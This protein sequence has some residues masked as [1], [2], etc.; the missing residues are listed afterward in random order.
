MPLGIDLVE[1]LIDPLNA[2][3]RSPS[4]LYH[5]VVKRSGMDLAEKG[6]QFDPPVGRREPWPVDIDLATNAAPGH[7]SAELRIP[8][9]AFDP[10][11]TEPTTWGFNITRYDAGR[12][13]FSTWSGATGNA[14]DP[15]SLGNLHLPSIRGQ[16]TRAGQFDSR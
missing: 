13:E 11:T 1:I 15:L 4:D 3:T 5:I 14:Y 8:L 2:G 7:W 16:E 12:Q 10:V 9:S 6:I